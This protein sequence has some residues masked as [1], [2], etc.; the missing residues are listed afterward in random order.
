MVAK[1]QDIDDPSLTVNNAKTS[2]T[3]VINFSHF[4][5]A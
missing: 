4:C 5:L 2:M 3:L 1:C